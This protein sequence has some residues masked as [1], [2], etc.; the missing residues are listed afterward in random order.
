MGLVEEYEETFE[1]NYIW[2]EQVRL[3]VAECLFNYSDGFPL[4]FSLILV[5]WQWNLL[6]CPRGP[7][8]TD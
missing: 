1:E 7:A 5:D 3:A 8:R 6:S 2:G 4:S